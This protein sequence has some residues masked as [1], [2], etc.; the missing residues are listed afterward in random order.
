MST[1]TCTSCGTAIPVERDE[2]VELSELGPIVCENCAEDRE[3]LAHGDYYHCN[4]CKEYAFCYP[5]ADG[6]ICENCFQHPPQG[7]Q[8]RNCDGC[9]AFVICYPVNEGDNWI[10]ATCWN[11]WQNPE[12]I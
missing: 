7:T 3:N 5:I 1:I 2:L 6:W 9:T 8:F 12:V 4:G 11:D 10:C